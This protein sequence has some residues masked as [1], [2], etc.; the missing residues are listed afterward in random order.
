VGEVLGATTSSSASTRSTT[1]ATRLPPEFVAAFERLASLATA[2][3][4]QGERFRVHAP[5][6]MMT[7]A[8]SSVA[9]SSSGSITA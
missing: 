6:Q 8:R 4:V 1:R 7:K 5:L 3:G 9:G 2:R